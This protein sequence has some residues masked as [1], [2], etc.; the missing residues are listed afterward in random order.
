M[1][2]GVVAVRDVEIYEKVLLR[3]PERSDEFDLGIEIGALCALMAQ[4][5]PEVQRKVSGAAA[6]Q[7]RPLAEHFRYLLNVETLDDDRAE[8]TLSLRGRRPM[9]RVV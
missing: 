6:H 1:W 3:F 7:L 5:T 2:F 4:R 8:V 9:L